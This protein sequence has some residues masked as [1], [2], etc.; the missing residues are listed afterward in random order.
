[1]NISQI[2]PQYMSSYFLRGPIWKAHQPTSKWSW[3]NSN[4]A[5]HSSRSM[6]L[7]VLHSFHVSSLTQCPSCVLKLLKWSLFG[8]TYLCE[9]LFSVMKLNKPTHRSCV[10]DEHLHSILR[11]SS[12]Q[13]L[14]PNIEELASKK[15]CQVSG[16]GPR[17]NLSAVNWALM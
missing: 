14:T 11:I 13:S 17:A 5:T 9:Q 6:T 1:M 2:I 16:S 4:V 8:S 10:T 15:R 3:S 12:A 7:L